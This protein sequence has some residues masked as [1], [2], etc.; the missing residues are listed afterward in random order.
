MFCFG[1]ITSV[2]GNNT[3]ARNNDVKN[4]I[5]VTLEHSR[6]LEYICMFLFLFLI[7]CQLY[8]IKTI[9]ST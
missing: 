3:N 7:N 1:H 9:L 6:A 8:N 5:S 4:T 2:Y